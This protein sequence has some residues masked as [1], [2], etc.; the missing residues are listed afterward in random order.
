VHTRRGIAQRAAV[1]DARP[2]EQ[3]AVDVEQK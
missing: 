1:L 2:L 3:R